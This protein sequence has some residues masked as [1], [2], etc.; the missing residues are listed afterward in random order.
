MSNRLL[1]RNHALC[2][3]KFI[4]SDPADGFGMVFYGLLN[5]AIYKTTQCFSRPRLRT[6]KILFDFFYKTNKLRYILCTCLFI[7]QFAPV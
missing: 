2:H 7:L 1:W 3:Y 5:T 4:R 6:V